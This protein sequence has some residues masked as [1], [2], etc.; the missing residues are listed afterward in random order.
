MKKNIGTPLLLTFITVLFSCAPGNSLADSVSW[1]DTFV[2]YQ[3]PSIDQC[4]SWHGFL[5]QLS[6]DQEFTGV[7]MSGTYAPNGVTITDPAAAQ[8]LAYLLNTKTGGSVTSDGHTWYVNVGCNIEPSC[9]TAEDAVELL[10]DQ[11][12]GCSC[13]AGPGYS[14]RPDVGV[15]HWGGVNTATCFSPF[16]TMMV[17]FEF[18]ANSDLDSD[19]IDDENDMCP[20]SDLSQTIMAGEFDSGVASNLLSS[21]GCTVNDQIEACGAEALNHGAFVS[22]V[23]A[24][25]NDLKKEGIISGKEKGAIQKLAA[26]ADMP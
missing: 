13:S 21:A 20:E 6:P 24:L 18:Q 12:G 5:G 9:V 11:E 23:S 17:T 25:L 4:E 3:T 10:I 14:V 2:K 8:E 26:K 16:Q 15:F 7:T 19:G 1:G 22:C